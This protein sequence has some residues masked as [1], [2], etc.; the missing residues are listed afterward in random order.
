M[1]DEA[2]HLKNEWWQTLIKVKEKLD[3]VT[4]GLTA[5][6]PYEKVTANFTG[7]C[8]LKYSRGKDEY[9]I[10]FRFHRSYWN[11][12][13]A[14][15]TAQRCLEYG[16]KELNVDRIVGRAKKENIGSVK[17]LEKIKMTFKEDFDF[18]GQRG[19]IYERTKKN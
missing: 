17:V 16:F 6:P 14:T 10:C 3:P 13:F 9:D 5:T 11:Q 12:G 8:G 18:E 4:V 19:V 1:V 15:E 2:H 7:W